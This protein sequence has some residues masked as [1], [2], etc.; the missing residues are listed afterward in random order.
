MNRKDKK[1]N[2]KK[3]TALILAGLLTASCVSLSGCGKKKGSTSDI[4]VADSDDLASSLDDVQ[5][6]IEWPDRGDEMTGIIDAM[7]MANTENPDITFD[8]NDSTSFWTYVYY[9]LVATGSDYGLASDDD[10]DGKYTMD[11]AAVKVYARFAFYNYD[12]QQNLPELPENFDGITY[13]SEK[14]EYTYWD[15]GITLGLS[16]VYA[17]GDKQSDGTYA[18]VSYMIDSSDSDNI[19]IV[20]WKVTIIDGRA[21]EDENPL[22]AYRVTN[23]EKVDEDMSS[24]VGDSL[25]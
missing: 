2:E 16:D 6:D 23:V 10:G 5:I 9:V 25:Q 8:V 21:S 4:S 20:P 12:G 24:A 1:I 14:D 7:I 19:I 18:T 11:T 17:I 15:R 3:I 22:Y 13:D